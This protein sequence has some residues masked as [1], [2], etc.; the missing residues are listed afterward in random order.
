VIVKSGA[1]IEACFAGTNIVR[2]LRLGNTSVG[3]IASAKTHPAYISGP[4]VFRVVQQGM[5]IS[6]R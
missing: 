5:S 3:D 6:F 4:G 1:R 2:Q